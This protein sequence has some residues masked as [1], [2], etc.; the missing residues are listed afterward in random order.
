MLKRMRIEAKDN[1]KISVIVP[2]YNTEKYLHRCIDSILAQTFTDFE[3]LL[4]DDGSTDRSG[5]ICDEYAQK[6]NRVRVFHKENGGV[7]SARNMGLDNARGEYVMFLDSDDYMFPEMCYI[8]VDTI[9]K[10]KS[11]MVICGTCET[12]GGFWRPQE[13]KTYSFQELK[14]NFVFLLH[15]ELLSPS[16][17]KI[18]RRCQIKH[19]FREDISFGED[20]IFNL[21][22]LKNCNRVSFIKTSPMFHEIGNENSLVVSFSCNR[23]KDIENVWNRVDAF[24]PSK[25]G[26]YQK[27]FCDLS[28]YVRQLFR[29]KRCDWKTKKKILKAWYK[30]A[31]L[32]RI[33]VGEYK[34]VYINKVLLFL[35]KHQQWNIANLLVNSKHYFL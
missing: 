33:K 7:S 6:D 32:R 8:L 27:Y 29:T 21:D 1:P 22:Y 25:K 19:Y 26:L 13:Y 12:G 11:D 20:L 18:F 4:V 2:V 9:K 23:L 34:G 24:A 10:E 28:V 3:L 30:V 31:L 5:A 16:W 14:N 17:N 35:L 15:T